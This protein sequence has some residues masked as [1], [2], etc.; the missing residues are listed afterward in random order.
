[1]DRIEALKTG[2]GTHAA[3]DGSDAL[4]S[5]MHDPFQRCAAMR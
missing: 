4:E 1:L 2:S 5:F 3:D